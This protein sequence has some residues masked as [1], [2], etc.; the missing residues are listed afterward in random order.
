MDISEK[1]KEYA[2]DKALEAITSAIEKAYA[3]GYNE[4]LQQQDN[5][6]LEDAQTG[7]TYVDLGL[8]SGTLWA[9]D[10]IEKRLTYL[11]ASKLSIPTFEQYEELYNECLVE[12]C[13][14]GIKFTG[15]NGHYIVIDYI[16]VQQ[17]AKSKQA[18]FYFWLEDGEEGNER[19]CACSPYEGSLLT[20]PWK[21]KLFMGIKLSVLLVHKVKTINQTYG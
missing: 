20:N 19:Y 4:G 17:V 6:K 3:D 15:R 12:S 8:T 10:Y 1:A 5:Q 9:S 14:K 21:Y 18:T 11:E 7:V 2:K 13:P 16:N